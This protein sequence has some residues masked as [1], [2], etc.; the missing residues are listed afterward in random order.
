MA[1]IAAEAGETHWVLNA[2]EP[3]QQQT[4]LNIVHTGFA[5]LDANDDDHSGS[6][7]DSD[8]EVLKKLRIGR[9]MFGSVSRVVHLQHVPNDIRSILSLGTFISHKP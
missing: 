4:S 2:K 1:K 8:E 5:D 6:E 3:A 7:S 9:M